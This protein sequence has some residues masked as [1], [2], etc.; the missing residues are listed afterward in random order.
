MLNR[1]VYICHKTYYGIWIGNEGPSVMQSCVQYRFFFPPKSVSHLTPSVSLC[2]VS[3]H[4]LYVSNTIQ[5][6]QWLPNKLHF[7]SV[8][9]VM[10]KFT[11]L[12]VTAIMATVFLNWAKMPGYLNTDCWIRTAF[13]WH[14]VGTN[15][16]LFEGGNELSVFIIFIHSSW[17]ERPTWCHLLYY[18]II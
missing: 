6:P 7:V 16:E 11:A 8:T 10:S 13:V 9:T 12:K 17:I 3:F 5:Q 2:S 14:S 18:F 15:Y 4:S 1:C